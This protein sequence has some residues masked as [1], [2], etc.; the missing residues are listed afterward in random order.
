MGGLEQALQAL[1]YHFP[2][3]TARTG[4]RHPCSQASPFSL[5][6][7]LLALIEPLRPCH[8]PACSVPDCVSMSACSAGGM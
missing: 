1:C 2:P 7:E 3:A 5:V 6:K 4:V 8:P